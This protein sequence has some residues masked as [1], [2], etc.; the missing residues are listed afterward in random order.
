MDKEMIIKELK[1]KIKDCKSDK[2]KAALKL[3][4][5]KLELNE[6]VTK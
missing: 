5:D 3:K 2:L 6:I 1:D 4:L